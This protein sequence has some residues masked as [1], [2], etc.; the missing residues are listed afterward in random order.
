MITIGY[1]PCGCGSELHG[2]QRQALGH[3]L[4][5]ECR[6]CMRTDDTASIS[7]D[8]TVSYLLS[9]SFKEVN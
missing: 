5:M 8:N 1:T 7:D 3:L 4:Y 2:V 6:W 9:M